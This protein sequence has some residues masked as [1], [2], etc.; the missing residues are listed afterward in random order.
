MSEQTPEVAE[1]MSI[2]RL[3]L[4]EDVLVKLG[5]DTGD[6]ATSSYIYGHR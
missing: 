3:Y 2:L 1:F 5:L 4:L 6:F